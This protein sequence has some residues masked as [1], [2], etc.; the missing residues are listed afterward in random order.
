MGLQFDGFGF[1]KQRRNPT[2]WNSDSKS[3]TSLFTNENDNKKG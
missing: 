3:V 1:V 2:D